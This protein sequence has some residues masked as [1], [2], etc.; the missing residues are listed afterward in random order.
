MA[1]GDDRGEPANIVLDASVR[2]CAVLSARGCPP[3]VTT[4]MIY[5]GIIPFVVIQLLALLLLS[6]FPWMATRL[7]KVIFAT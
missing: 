4:G 1:R 5:K 2:F 3:E 6:L 7:P